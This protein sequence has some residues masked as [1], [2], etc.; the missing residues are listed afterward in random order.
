MNMAKAKE[1]DSLGKPYL[2]KIFSSRAPFGKALV[3][4]YLVPSAV[5]SFVDMNGS[6]LEFQPLP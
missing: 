6:D 5:S 3:R 4:G 2:A 1:P